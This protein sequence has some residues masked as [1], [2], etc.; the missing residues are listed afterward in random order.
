MIHGKYVVRIVARYFPMLKN[1]LRK[2]LCRYIILLLSSYIYIIIL[3]FW[4]ETM[5]RVKRKR[6]KI[7]RFHNFIGIGYIYI[8]IIMCFNYLFKFYHFNLCT[9]CA[10]KI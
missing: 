9:G 6:K 3:Q 8:C 7:I 4:E 1:V 10:K 5:E 2:N